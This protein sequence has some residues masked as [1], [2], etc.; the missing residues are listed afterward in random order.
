MQLYHLISVNSAICTNR[1]KGRIVIINTAWPT[2][3]V[4]QN[5]FHEEELIFL[6]SFQNICNSTDDTQSNHSMTKQSDPYTPAS[7]PF[8]NTS[9]YKG[10]HFRLCRMPM[11][12]PKTTSWAHHSKHNRHRLKC[13]SNRIP[14]WYHKI[15]L[16]LDWNLC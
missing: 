16:A 3:S 9:R 6:N 15:L 14:F 10:S 4:D 8:S 2:G 11:T 5:I 7:G 1:K 12:T 13:L